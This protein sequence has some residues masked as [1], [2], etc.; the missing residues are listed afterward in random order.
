MTKEAVQVVVEQMVGK[1]LPGAKVSIK[2]FKFT[3]KEAK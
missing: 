2:S 3:P 1:H